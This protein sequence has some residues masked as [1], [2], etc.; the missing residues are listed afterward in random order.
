MCQEKRW[1]SSVQLTLPGIAKM[2]ERHQNLQREVDAQHAEQR[3]LRG[4]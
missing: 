4:P 2:A 1:P 3:A